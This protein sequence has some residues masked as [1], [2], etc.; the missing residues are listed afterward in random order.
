MTFDW[1]FVLNFLACVVFSNAAMRKR[2]ITGG[3][4]KFEEGDIALVRDWCRMVFPAKR[5]MAE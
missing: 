3:L 4:R 1:P 5:S 2:E